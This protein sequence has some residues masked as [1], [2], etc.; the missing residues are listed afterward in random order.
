[1][2]NCTES[3]SF[4]QYTLS[5]WSKLF[6]D[7]QLPNSGPDLIYNWFYKKL[8]TSSWVPNLAKSSQEFL[9]TNFNFDLPKIVTIHQSLDKTVKFLVQFKDNLKVEMV[10][11]PFNRKYTLCL[12]SQVG[13]A[14]NCSFCFTGTQGLSRSLKTEEIVG[15][16][17]VAKNWLMLNRIDEARLLNIVFMGQGEPLHNFDA[18][19]KACEIFIERRGIGLAPYKVTVSTAGYLP[20][21]LR[22]K[23][24]MVDVNIAFSLHSVF[25]ETRNRLV[26]LNKKYPFDQL[27][28]IL[29]SIPKKADR[30]VTYE[31]AMIKGVNDSLDEAKALGA[32]L[33]KRKAYVSL[34]PFNPYP[35]SQYERSSMEQI[36][37]FQ[38][39]LKQFKLPALIRI[40]KGDEIL[41]ACGQ[42]KTLKG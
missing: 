20:G 6:N 11:I 34:I 22:W 5:D 14:M 42:L 18:V 39:V 28:P 36:L 23:D 41:A 7:H 1:M 33:E 17:I 31:Y 9:N 24:E 8:K 3:Q 40:T 29:D 38:S 15:Q 10:L 32:L 27:I 35:G 13:C 4:Y 21:L 19:K 30:F 12:S 2:L 16:F 26:P 37:K 25:H